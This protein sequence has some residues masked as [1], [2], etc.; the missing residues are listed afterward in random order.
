MKKQKVFYG[1]YI[2]A[3]GFLVFAL[4]MGIVNNCAGVFIKPLCEAFGFPRKAVNLMS[5]I[6]G[7]CGM[8]LALFSGRF[9]RRF[10][11][12][13]TMRFAAVALAG[14]YF[15]YSYCRSLP[16]FYLVSVIVGFSQALLVTVSMSMLLNNWFHE[17]RGTAVG[18]AFMGSGIGGMLFNP[19]ANALIEAMGWQGAY[20]VLAVLMGALLIPACFLVL[21]N[22][23]ADLGLTPYGAGAQDPLAQTPPAQ[24]EGF[25]LHE[26]QHTLHFWLFCL[27]NFVAIFAMCCLMTQVAPHLSD[28]GYSPSFAAVMTSLCMGSLALGKVILGRLYDKL[29]VR[30]A[31]MFSVI[32]AFFGFIGMLL[33]PFKPA[34]GLIVV[35]SG[36]GSCFGSV[37]PPVLTQTLYGKKD[38]GAILGRLSACGNAAGMLCPVVMGTVY[39]SFGSYRPIFMVLVVVIA[40]CGVGYLRLF[41]TMPRKEPSSL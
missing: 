19:L 25:T 18:I 21:R 40:L 33:V 4:S 39:D 3:A 29:G 8:L 7:A 37:A 12:V 11:V 35:G 32:A 14:S 26:L 2:V 22:S 34:L 30:A 13:K 41:A 24:A 28:V 38:Y 9:Y 20:R 16:M 27:C 10:D 17:K 23:P 15:A 31:T 1:W 36:F 6:C 5:T